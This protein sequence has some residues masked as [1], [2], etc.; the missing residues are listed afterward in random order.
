[1]DEWIELREGSTGAMFLSEYDYK[2]QDPKVLAEAVSKKLHGGLLRI[3]L[4]VGYVGKMN[5]NNRLYLKSAVEDS[6]KDTKLA[7]REGSIHGTHGAHPSTLEVPPNQIS[8]LVTDAWVDS[9]NYIWNE[10]V[11]VPTV[12]GKDLAALFLSGTKIGCSTRGAGMGKKV[13]AG[14]E[15]YKYKFAGTDTVGRPSTGVAASIATPKVEIELLGESV[16]LTESKIDEIILNKTLKEE[17]V[18]KKEST[19]TLDDV[20]S[21]IK[22]MKD[23]LIVPNE[24]IKLSESVTLD[25]FKKVQEELSAI[26]TELENYK[27][28]YKELEES[29]SSLKEQTE[30]MAETNSQD[31][32]EVKEENKVLIANS[33]EAI[34]SLKS[35]AFSTES[36]VEEATRYIKFLENTAVGELREYATTTEEVLSHAVNYVHFLEA[37]MDKV[38]NYSKT[39]ERVLE[40]AINYINKCE[41]G[42]LA[43]RDYALKLEEVIKEMV[44]E[45]KGKSTSVSSAPEEIKEAVEGFL[46]SS[47][48]LAVFKEEMLES[49]SIQVLRNKVNKYMSIFG[50]SDIKMSNLTSIVESVNTNSKSIKGWK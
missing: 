25:S 29:H 40:N 41:D 16:D 6:F 36:V 8:H 9:N 18:E 1:M 5:E 42:V 24:P 13:E 23:K 4:P 19:A 7:M 22:E 21:S 28:T 37:N 32:S 26:T 45:F 44:S 14:E 20:F 11:V 34:E 12:L 10:W 15:I 43:L 33:T 17:I 3:K 35:Y 50:N 49:A 47:P 31:L 39:S 27:K 30:F 48:K 38:V 2:G 46:K